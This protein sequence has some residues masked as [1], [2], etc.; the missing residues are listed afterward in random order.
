MERKIVTTKCK[1]CGTR[2]EQG[3][4]WRNVCTPRCDAELKMLKIDK[5]IKRIPI[6]QATEKTLEQRAIFKQNVKEL[7]E[8]QIQ[9]RGYTYCERCGK[10]CNPSAHHLVW[11]SEF[12]NHTHLHDKR[13]LYLVCDFRIDSCHDF[14]HLDKKNRKEL[15]EERDLVSLFGNSILLYS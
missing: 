15:V 8:A 5:A 2:F 9:E 13:N 10:T 12:P 6:K 7:K 14:M 4:R 3:S 1:N 11:R